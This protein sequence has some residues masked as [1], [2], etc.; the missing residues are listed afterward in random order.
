M[1]DKTGVG[2]FLRNKPNEI[3][4]KMKYGE[5]GQT[6]DMNAGIITTTSDLQDL[7]AELM[8]TTTYPD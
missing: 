2:Q 7:Y 8:N 3:W 6:P 4:Q 1:G 5:P